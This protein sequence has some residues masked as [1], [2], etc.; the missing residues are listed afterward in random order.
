MQ[1]LAGK[2]LKIRLSEDPANQRSA[3][4]ISFFQEA[5]VPLVIITLALL[6]LFSSRAWFYFGTSFTVGS[7][8]NVLRTQ[9]PLGCFLKEADLIADKKPAVVPSLGLL[10]L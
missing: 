6:D 10:D 9:W 8:D 1:R 2:D 5:R 7:P 3:E 4:S